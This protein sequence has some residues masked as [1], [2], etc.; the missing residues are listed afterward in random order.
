MKFKTGDK[1]KFLNEKGGGVVTKNISPTMVNVMISD[2]FEIPV[3]TGDLIPVATEGK[4]ASMFEEDLG[5]DF[6]PETE[7]RGSQKAG[8]EIGEEPEEESRLLPLVNFSFRTK[9]EPSIYLAYVPHDQKWLVTG[10]LDIYLVNHTGYDVIFSLFMKKEDR[11]EG[12]DYDVI[13]PRH[14]ILLD[15]IEREKLNEWQ[16]G[17][18]QLLFHTDTPDKILTPVSQEFK[19]RTQRLVSENSYSESEFI[20]ERALVVQMIT[21][22]AVSGIKGAEEKEEKE[23][24]PAKKPEVQKP[25]A[26]IDKYRTGLH[27]AVVD[28][29]MEELVGDKEM[30][31]MMPHEMLNYQLRY[32]ERCIES[33]IGASYHKVTFIHGV[34]NGALKSALIKRLQEYETLENHSASLAKFGV[35]AIDVL[36]RPMK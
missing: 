2:G 6:K 11:Y 9:N 8:T 21:M 12:A 19:V 25:G 36:I 27:E 33:A 23:P 16:E 31:K 5:V 29:H 4:T 10:E 15:T 24:S 20:E 28:L 35:G 18:V 13:P 34:G 1:V 32:F 14:K 26:F 22:A 3:M 17:I 30:K 7:S